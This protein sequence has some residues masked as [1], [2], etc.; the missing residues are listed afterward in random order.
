MRIYPILS[1]IFSLYLMVGCN[2][3]PREFTGIT[4]FYDGK[5]M[6]NPTTKE[7]RYLNFE[8]DIINIMHELKC[9]GTTHFPKNEGL[10]KLIKK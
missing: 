2:T 5:I 7:I 3:A 10:D 4:C 8:D 1:G 9:D 6:I